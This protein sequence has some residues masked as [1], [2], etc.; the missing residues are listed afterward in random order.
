MNQLL[1][2]REA[3][4]DDAGL[5]RADDDFDSLLFCGRCGERFRASEAT[6]DGWYYRC[7]SDD[8]DAEGI[9]EELY[10]VKDVL[11]SSH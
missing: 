5:S 8:C 4:T 7:P 11:P 10:P 6:D 3:G 9:R 1:Q 2:S